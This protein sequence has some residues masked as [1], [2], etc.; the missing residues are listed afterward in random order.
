VLLGRLAESRRRDQGFLLGVGLFTA[1][2]AACGAADSLTM[3]VIFRVLQAAGAALLTPTSLS[4]VLAT[5]APERRHGAVRAWTAVGGLAAALGPVVGGVL[6]AASWRWVFLVNV[7]IGLVALVAG[8]RRLPA[9]PGHPVRTPDALGA[10]LVTGGVAALTLGLVKG[11]DWGWGSGSTL[12]ALT[13]SGIALALFAVHCA[14][15]GNPLISADLFR[16]RTFTGASL[17]AVLFSIAFG[18]MLLSIVLWDQE[19][20]HWSALTT[21]L[22][23]APG[24]LMVPLFSFLVAG[25]HAPHRA[26]RGPDAAHVH[27]HR[28]LVAAPGGVCHG[29]GRGQHAPPG[30]TGRGRG[31]AGRGPGHA[32]VAGRRTDRLCARLVRRG[33]GRAP[34]RVGRSTPSP[35]RGGAPAGG[36]DHA[37][38]SRLIHRD[39][40]TKRREPSARYSTPR[41]G[42]PREPQCGAGGPG[43]LTMSRPVGVMPASSSSC[44]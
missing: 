40:V 8:W 18:A 43:G 44:Q 41:A 21:G 2:S 6:V 34:G 27:G 28:R 36:A 33:R 16:A 1:A 15:A 20:W 29:L 9:V 25:R 13:L 31:G 42:T 10:G 4:L 14:R 11:H 26:R 19:V 32:R 35:P 17:V 12:T 30:R 37:G 7:P 38:A 23:V 5:T 24:P 3:L 39:A 22:A